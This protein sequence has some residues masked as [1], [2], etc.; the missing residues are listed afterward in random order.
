MVF[1]WFSVGFQLV[2]VEFFICCFFLDFGFPFSPLEVKTCTR[3]F[4]NGQPTIG[5]QP[6]AFG[7]EGGKALDYL[8]CGKWNHWEVVWAILVNSLVLKYPTPQPQSSCLGPITRFELYMVGV[9]FATLVLGL[10]G[11]VRWT[12]GVQ[13]VVS[14]LGLRHRGIT[15]H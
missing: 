2:W 12:F 1:S 6:F 10:V 15:A 3:R 5:N 4:E 13:R 7:F 14:K 9:N 11:F 8:P